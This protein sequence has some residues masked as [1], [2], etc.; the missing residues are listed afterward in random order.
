[1]TH[2][3]GPFDLNP[4]KD[5]QPANARFSYVCAFT[6]RADLLVLLPHLRQPLARLPLE[7]LQRRSCPLLGLR[8]RSGRQLQA[9][10]RPTVNHP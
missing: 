3:T 2:T 7:K 9:P 1:M 5:A 6:C 10:S 4:L 8:S